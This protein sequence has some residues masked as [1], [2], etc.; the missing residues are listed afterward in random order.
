MYNIIVIIFFSCECK[1]YYNIIMHAHFYPSTGS[2]V[3]FAFW[4][5]ISIIYLIVKKL[6]RPV[7]FITDLVY[8]VTIFAAI[9]PPSQLS[10]YILYSRCIGIGTHVYNIFCY[11][12][13]FH[14]STNALNNLWYRHGVILCKCF[15]KYVRV[16]LWWW[17]YYVGLLK[18]I[19]YATAPYV[20]IS[21]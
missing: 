1:S 9:S 8:T 10:A 5:T 17:Y 20:G 19:S 3:K 4:L 21:F 16:Q 6:G 15:S 11:L 18:R 7:Y 12:M 13:G 2:R 14:K